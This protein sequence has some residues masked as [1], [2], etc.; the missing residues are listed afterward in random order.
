MPAA[1]ARFRP[2]PV[3]SRISFRSNSAMEA[4]SV[5][6]NRP[7]AD[8]MSQSGSPSERKACASPA[9]AVDQVKKLPGRAAKPIKLAHNDDI[10][11]P[12]PDVGRA[13]PS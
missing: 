13:R 7:C 2:S 9:Y 5:E 12:W 11:A 10:A 4:K 3:R 8:D 1:I 6:S